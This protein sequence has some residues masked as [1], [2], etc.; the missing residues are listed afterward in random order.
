MGQ[1]ND[2]LKGAAGGSEERAK[3]VHQQVN[4]SS[5][6]IHDYLNQREKEKVLEKE[7]AKA[8]IDSTK[9]ELGDDDLLADDYLKDLLE[10]DDSNLL[11]NFENLN[12]ENIMLEGEDLHVDLTLMIE[13]PD[14]L[15]EKP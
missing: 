1:V 13:V 11:D 4:M 12:I 8:K 15:A 10:L 2:R 14:Y 3:E 5:T 7:M 6:F 9:L